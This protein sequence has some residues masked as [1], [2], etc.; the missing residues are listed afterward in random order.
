MMAIDHGLQGSE[1][2]KKRADESR[3]RLDEMPDSEARV[4]MRRIAR[5]YD[6][7]AVHAATREARENDPD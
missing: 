3:A 5:M 7:L 4:L 6:L 1:Y 2:W